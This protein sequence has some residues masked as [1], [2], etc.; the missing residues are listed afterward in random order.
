MIDDLLGIIYPA[1]CEVC[2][3]ALLEGESVLCLNCLSKLP[4]KI[5]HGH[6]D[7]SLILK[8]A[9]MARVRR[10]ASFFMYSKDAGTAAIIKKA[11]YGNQPQIAYNLAKIFASELMTGDFFDGID[12]IVPVPMHWWKQALRG[13]NQCEEIARGLSEVTGIPVV[14]NLVACRPH[15]TQTRKT[16]ADRKRLD[17]SIFRVIAPEELAGKHMLVVDDVITTGTT[18]AVACNVL[19]AAQ[20]SAM[21]SILSLAK[22]H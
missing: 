5:L 20:P 14:D 18:I 12:C 2:G 10:V 21:V 22:A 8:F 3:E 16:V 6:E 4:R 19:L 13:Y 11:K 17:S 7:H 9:G 1:T 15:K